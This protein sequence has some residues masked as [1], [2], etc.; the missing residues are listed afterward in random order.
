MVAVLHQIPGCVDA[1]CAQVY[2]HHYFGADQLR[3]F[4]E[5]IGANLIGFRNP[6][7]QFKRALTFFLGSDTVFP[8]IAGD[9]VAARIA[10]NRNV[11]R[12]DSLQ[13]VSA[14]AVLIGSRMSGFINT[15]VHSPAKMFNEGP[16]NSRINF[17]Q[18]EILVNDH[19]RFYCHQ[20]SSFEMD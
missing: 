11:Q 6:P 4:G 8:V 5:F 10:D 20:C 16:V 12:T 17:T 3:P 14:E 2:R 9:E 13:G 7:G 1:A 18:S 19:C 15:A